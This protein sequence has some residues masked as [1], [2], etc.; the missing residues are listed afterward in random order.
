LRDRSEEFGVAA[1][2]EVEQQRHN[3]DAFRQD[4]DQLFERAGAAGR[5]DHSNNTAPQCE[6]HG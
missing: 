2:L 3:A 6:A 5:P 4:A 1:G